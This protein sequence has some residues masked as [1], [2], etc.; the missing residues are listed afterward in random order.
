MWDM[1]VVSLEAFFRRDRGF[2]CSNGVDLFVDLNGDYS[3]L[4][5]KAQFEVAFTDAG[6]SL[7]KLRCLTCDAA[8][9]M[10]VEA[11]N[12]FSSLMRKI[13]KVCSADF[14]DEAREEFHRAFDNQ[15]VHIRICLIWMWH[16]H[17]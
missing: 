2:T 14:E 13:G 9:V 12:G 15:E 4:N 3:A 7:A 6:I 16:S 17:P 5:L 1:W 8:S 11:L 10:G